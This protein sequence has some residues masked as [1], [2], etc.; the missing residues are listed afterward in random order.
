M[1]NKYLLLTVFVFLI[2]SA[3]AQQKPI[4]SSNGDL[5]GPWLLH[6]IQAGEELSTARVNLTFSMNA[7]NGSF[8]DLSLDGTLHGNQISLV[9]KKPNGSF[10]GKIEG[11]IAGSQVKG[12]LTRGSEV[13][14]LVLR[15]LP[16]LDTVPQTRTFVP[17]T[18][19]RTFDGK[20]VPVM[21]LNS[22]D[23][24]K[25]TTIDA[26]GHDENGAQKS[27]GGN[28]QT[29]PF[30][31]EGAVPG[32]TLSI[33]LKRLRLNR[34][35]ALS[36]SSIAPPALT[37]FY[38]REEKLDPNVSG[39]WKLDLDR[40]EAELAAPTEK[41]K[42]YRVSLHPMLGC[43]AVAPNGKQSFRTSWLGS[44]GGNMDYNRLQE[45]T[46][47][48]LPVFVE[49]ALLFVGDAHAMQGDG[50]I[51]GDAL[52]TSMNVEFTVKVIPGQTIAGPRA[53]NDQYL[54]A[55]GISGSVQSAM[56]IATSELAQWIQSEYKLNANETA[57]VMGTSVQYDIAEVVDPQVNVVARISRSA[58]ATIA[59]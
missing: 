40:N 12:T 9:A 11:E 57:I 43:I 58:L 53:E 45:G 27:I 29:G 18:Y 7:I 34:T 23:T 42:S 14:E 55:M 5:S 51:N 25:T 38:F 16:S 35:S 3:L 21:H 4:T 59:K 17:T 26:A 1:T 30:Y 39:N 19:L 49:G 47:V 6:L 10:Y 13:T 22:G 2:H 41:L 50:E 52:E 32:D 24:V 48:F 15:K 33:T 28:P 54:M 36:D 20:A 8:H 31:V 46:T 56:Q 37:P 44:W